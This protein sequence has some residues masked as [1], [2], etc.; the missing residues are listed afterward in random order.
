MLCDECG[1]NIA[2]VYLTQIVN[3]KVSKIR[4]C[5]ECSM[6]VSQDA[7]QIGVLFELPQFVA[8]FL[9]VENDD[10][11]GFAELETD[12][13]SCK[14]CGTSINDIKE[15]GYLGCS[16]CYEIFKDRLEPLIKR[17]HSGQKHIGKVPMM[18]DSNIKKKVKIEELQKKIKEHV[19]KEEY[20]QAAELRD[21]IRRLNTEITSDK[22]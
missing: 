20:E 22:K 10:F 18:I 14:N 7:N 19:E 2:T 9:G 3:N 11:D 5:E 15:T 6:K 16:N 17:I 13:R 12:S 4:L 21:N 8:G 1:K